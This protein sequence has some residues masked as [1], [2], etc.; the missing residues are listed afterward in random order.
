MRE[1]SR[2]DQIHKHMVE[3]A[4]QREFQLQRLEEEGKPVCQVLYEAKEETKQAIEDEI[5]ADREFVIYENE[6]E[7]ARIVL[8]AITAVCLADW[9]EQLKR[10]NVNDSLT[11][12]FVQH[13][14]EIKQNE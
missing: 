5:D 8:D 13:E 14:R 9:L 11:W 12:R 3:E 6:Y 2:P 1:F 4:K 7:T 10:L